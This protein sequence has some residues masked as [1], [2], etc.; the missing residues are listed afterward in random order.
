MYK[1][2]DYVFAHLRGYSAWPAIIKEIE[3]KGRTTCYYVNFFGPNKETGQCTANK[4]YLFEENKKKFATGKNME[5][6][7]FLLAIKEVENEIKINNSKN[8]RSPMS[9]SFSTPKSQKLSK[10]TSTSGDRYQSTLLDKSVNTTIELDPVFQLEA[11]TDK[12]IDLEKKL[13]Q[14]EENISSL[15][16]TQKQLKNENEHL[17]NKNVQ[18]ENK[19]TKLAEQNQLTQTEVQ[20]DFQT[21]ILLKELNNKKLEHDNL[22]E[23]ANILQQEN[24]TLQ[25]ELQELK[26]STGSCINCFPPM[27]STQSS[28]NSSSTPW[29]Q[30]HSTNRKARKP[31]SSYTSADLLCKNSFASLA[32][33]DQE[34]AEKEE[35]TDEDEQAK[36]LICGDSHGRDL[37]YHLNKVQESNNAFAFIK[38][39]GRSRD[40]LNHKSIEG[41]NLKEDDVMVIV[42]GTNDVSENN[43]SEALE[44]MKH[45]INK[46]SNT[47]IVLVDLPIR[48]DLVQ[49]S[50]VNQEVRKTNVALNGLCQD[51]PNVILVEASRAERH[52]HTR[53]GMH[54]N[55]K[56]KMWLAD[57]IAKAINK[58]TD[59][60]QLE[61]RQPPP[62]GMEPQA[63]NS[64][65]T[66][67]I[68][69]P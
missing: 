5:N 45:T 48:Y 21:Q 16:E 57:N 56:G 34:E 31:R 47:K 6:K 22:K 7:D 4:L 62:P 61:P 69:Q 30:V 19:L 52:Y 28:L 38:P 26:V 23:A 35:D 49:W 55:Y 39:G 11:L 17:R 59:V 2:G 42:S 25:T 46:F 33:T 13:L 15:K 53:H 32:V 29:T 67:P 43:A 64:S 36:I 18:L 3:N 41:V 9:I 40:V 44:I 54:F 27:Q 24:N 10:K 58:M 68:Q 8:L 65:E 37:A 12:C 51:Y 1:V 66:P 50:C 60:R 14:Y 20:P 63:E